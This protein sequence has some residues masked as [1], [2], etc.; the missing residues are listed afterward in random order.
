MRVAA[1]FVLSLV[2]ACIGGA[3]TVDAIEKPNIIFI[4]ADDLGYGDLECYG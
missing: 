2:L 3:V 4:M 1:L